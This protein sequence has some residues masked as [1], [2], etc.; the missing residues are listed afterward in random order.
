MTHFLTKKSTTTRRKLPYAILSSAAL[1]AMLALSACG[2]EAKDTAA[3]TQTAAADPGTDTAVETAAATTEPATTGD[4]AAA[5]EVDEA[6]AAV[7]EGA[8]KMKDETAKF[9]EALAA[10]DDAQVKALSGSINDVWLSYENTVRDQFPLL[11]TEVEKYE[12]PIFSASAYDKMDYPS[13]TD[14]AEKLQGALDN[15]LTAKKTSAAA[16]EVL[17]QAVTGYETYVREQTD[18]F[19]EETQV[20][21]DAVKAGDIDKAKAAYATSRAYYENIEPIAES[22]GDLDPKIDARL[23]D[24]E[25]EEQWTGFHR[26]ERALW[27]DGSLEGQDKYAD[28]LM[29]DVKALQAKVSELKLEPEAM[30][31]GAMELLNEAATSKITGEEETYSHTDLV[32]LAA[33]VEGSKA[34]Y[35]AIIPALNDGHQEL[36]DQLDQQF[37]TMEKTLSQYNKD[38]QYA[39]YTDLKTEQIRELSDQLSQLSELMSQTAKIL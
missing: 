34:V 21:A 11:Y 1:A 12:M 25:S 10:N 32:D 35:F 30:V 17:A 38:G 5:G 28:L 7:R 2:T 20:F 6:T 31:A 18:R 23:P 8:Q 22:L 9:Q 24:V 3:T 36:A 29:T 27:E 16:S 26:I 13:L 4:A 37:Q 19:V 15:L 14:S 39:L 33:N